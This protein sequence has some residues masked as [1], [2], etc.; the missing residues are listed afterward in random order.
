ML[1]IFSKDALEYGY[2]MTDKVTLLRLVDYIINLPRESFDRQNLEL[3]YGVTDSE[4][5]IFVI[6]TYY[7]SDCIKRCDNGVDDY[8][9]AVVTENDIFTFFCQYGHGSITYLD[10][11]GHDDYL[12]LVSGAILYFNSVSSYEWVKKLKLDNPSFSL[13]LYNEELKN[14]Y[15]NSDI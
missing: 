11:G 1:D 8:K 9:Y 4:N 6:R 14:T 13:R 12:S 7:L 5:T 15:L 2:K 3:G 10:M